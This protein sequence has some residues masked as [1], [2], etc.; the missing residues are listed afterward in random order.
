MMRHPPLAS[1]RADDWAVEWGIAWIGRTAKL[2]VQSA[3]PIAQAVGQDDDIP[4]P[5]RARCA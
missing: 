1:V 2:S 5:T 4:A 3:E